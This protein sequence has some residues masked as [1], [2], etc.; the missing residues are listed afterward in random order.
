MLRKKRIKP[1]QDA[2]E[3]ILSGKDKAFIEGRQ[4]NT[5]KGRGV[6]A[7][8]HI[9][10]STFVVEYRG[11][12]SQSKHVKDVQGNYLFDFTWN[13]TRYCIDATKEDSGHS[14]GRLV[15][16]DDKNP[17]CKV[18]TI[19]V[20]GRPHLCLFSIRH[21]FP[22]EEVTYNYGDSSWPWRLRELC[23]ETSVAVTECSVNPSSSVKQKELCDETSVAVTECSVNPS[24]SVKQKCHHEVHS[25]VISSLDSCEDCSGPVSSRK[26]LGLT[27]KL[28][29]RSWHKTCFLNMTLPDV[30]FSSFEESGSD[31]EY[32]PHADKH[33]EESSSDDFIPD[34]RQ[35]SDSDDS[36]SINICNPPYYK[37][38]PAF[39][40]SSMR[41]K[42]VPPQPIPCSSTEQ[43]MVRSSYAEDLTCDDHDTTTHNTEMLQSFKKTPAVSS[44]ESSETDNVPNP[45]NTI[46]THKNYC[47]VCKK[48]QSKIAR[49][50][51]KHQDSETEIAAAFLLP[52]HSQDRKR[53][54]QK[55]RNRG[56]YEHNQEVMESKSGPLK[57]RR[58]PGRSDIELSAKTY[59]HCVYCKGM[60]VRKELWRH[61]RRCPSKMF[62]ESEATGKAKVLVLADIAESTFSQA[63]SPEVWKILGNMK[64]DDISS[65]VRNDFLI[66]QL[67]QCLYNKHGSDPTKSEYI[68]QK[69]R[70]MGRLL[71]TLRKKYFIFSFEDAVKPNNFYKVIEA[72]KDVAG[73]DEKS[74]SYK[75]PSLALKLG[76][77]L[78]KIGDIIL[79]RAI[80]AEDD[81][82]TKAAERFKRLCSSEWAEHVSHA[83]LAT[84]NKSKFNK[85]S[86]IPF[87]H[88]V[89]LLHQHLEKKSADAF[90]SLKNH[91]SSQT[92]AELAKV[93]LAQVIIFN[94]RRAGEVSKMTLECFR[95]RDQTEL[96]DDIA[97]SL[98]PFEQKMAKHFSRVEIMGKKGRKVAILLNP[99]L[100][101]AIKL[102]VDKRD[103]CEVDGDNPFLF[104][105]PKCSP[106]SFFRGQ[107]CIRLFASQCGAQH[108]EYLRSTQLRKQVATMSQV[109]NLKDN[110]LDQLANFLG[111]DIRVHRDY[112]RLP[113]A[114]IEIAKI[115]KLLLAMEKGTLVNFQG[116]SL[117]EIEIEDE[118][119]LD[120]DEEEV[121]DDDNEES[122]PVSGV[123]GSKEGMKLTQDKTESSN[124]KSQMNQ[125]ETEN[126]RETKLRRIVKRP[127]SPN[128]VN[129]VMKHFRVH[130]SKGH[131]ATKAECEQCKAAEDPLLR[132]RT[133][134]NIR[135]FVRNRGLMLKKKSS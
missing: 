39:S 107:D 121:S 97:V 57:V 36:V 14:L 117:D 105:R 90:E 133:A 122:E 129:A 78:N 89:Q 88:D 17:N 98:S 43:E 103:A 68:R 6:F 1:E 114:T 128:E 47:Y 119:D 100:V 3:H 5:F 134:Q 42:S 40:E 93:T 13:G 92:Y 61:T 91:E 82:M 115:S 86:T 94:R 45:K 20:D 38:T 10:P 28:C 62:S 80:A 109:L 127:W 49:H 16:D 96:H 123:S 99:E 25:A 24:S 30:E 72:V 77:S 46:S 53:L 9:E 135:D 111:H 74:H 2:K 27:C 21:I 35:N 95:K 104:G 15:N 54:L 63:I 29:S 4:I 34:S 44:C 55:L 85:P 79:C 118:I 23:D 26:W 81:G 73:Y 18:K 125:D 131:L 56:N 112:Y 50:F 87:T 32:S 110:E 130:I 71:L 120:L 59:V 48:P 12:L 37:S 126:S 106:N 7:L 113:D 67:S 124:G 83:A 31:E 41:A 8:E 101:R 108:P 65:V 64:I 22:D 58:R 84:L 52:K 116:K 60:F 19:I 75:T 69:V 102:L 51:K 11:I 33:T 132:E 70:E 66:L 76:H